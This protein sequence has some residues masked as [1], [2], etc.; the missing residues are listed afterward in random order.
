ME[1]FEKIKGGISEAVKKTLS[2]FENVWKQ[3][4]EFVSS[5]E[6][7][8]AAASK[9]GNSALFE[10]FERKPSLRE[11]MCDRMRTFFGKFSPRQKIAL[12]FVLGIVLG[13]GTKAAA[14]D[15]ITM[16]Y[17]DY[18]ASKT[19]AYDLIGLQKKVAAQG[20]STAV[21]GGVPTAGSCSQ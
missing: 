3:V 7:D 4:L 21:T 14:H 18:T 13:A 15:R 10:T 17:R 12:L 19:N 16:G 2:Y 6:D 5:E 1:I 8:S 20:G 11:K 9:P